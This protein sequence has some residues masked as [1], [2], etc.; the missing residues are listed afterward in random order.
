MKIATAKAGDVYLS[1]TDDF[2]TADIDV[3]YS[4]ESFREMKLRE[5]PGGIACFGDG[6]MAAEALRDRVL[7]TL[8]MHDELVAAVKRLSFAAQTT[9]G[10]AGRDDE[11]VAAIAQ[12]ETVLAK[13]E[14]R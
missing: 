14:A 13:V 10:T 4:M 6:I 1:G 5:H 11:L 2:H 3:E 7:L 9:G 8:T 12:A